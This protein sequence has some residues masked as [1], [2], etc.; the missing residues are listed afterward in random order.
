MVG[1]AVVGA[2]S[3]QLA[4][5]GPTD[6]LLPVCAA[7]GSPGSPGSTCGRTLTNNSILKIPAWAGQRQL[8]ADASIVRSSRRCA[9]GRH[10]SI[11]R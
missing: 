3:F 5:G 8:F 2:E 4:A 1:L 11:G 9:A 6:A 7:L 10:V